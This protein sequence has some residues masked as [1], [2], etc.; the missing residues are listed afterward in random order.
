MS[1]R[2]LWAWLVG[3]WAATTSFMTLLGLAAWAAAWAGALM[4]LLTGW[5]I[6]RLI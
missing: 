4:V 6:G 2:E 1:T 3:A 5:L